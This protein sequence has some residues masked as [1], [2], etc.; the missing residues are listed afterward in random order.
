MSRVVLVFLLP[1]LAACST[2]YEL[3]LPPE[4]GSESLAVVQADGARRS[5]RVDTEAGRYSA[6]RISIEGPDARLVFPFGDERTVPLAEVQRIEF[7]HHGRGALEGI[8]IG[9]LAGFLIGAPL[10]AADSG[11]WEPGEAAL[12]VGTAFGIIAGGVG[13]LAGLA[14]GH[15]VRV[16]VV[17]GA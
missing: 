11:W 10:G 9:F 2:T 17:P 4:P 14:S 12:L 3:A 8:G 15:K 16:L 7:R 6:H 5:A 13:L 1:A